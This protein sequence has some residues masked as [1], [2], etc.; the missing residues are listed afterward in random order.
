M[1]YDAEHKE[2]TRR[3]VLNEAA[4][5]IR[6]NGPDRIGIAAIM[7]KA[8]LTHGGFYAHFKSKDDLVAQAVTQMFDDSWER[9]M[10]R[11]EGLEPAAALSKL[12]DR[13]LDA[14]HRDAPDKGCPMPSLSGEL[15]RMPVEA[16]QRFADGAAR[17]TQAIASRLRALGRAHPEATATSVVSE[18]V[19][20]LSLARAIADPEHSARVLKDSRAAIRTRLELESPR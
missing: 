13:Y 1:R 5:A 8:G 16:R 11:V 9:I 18:M 14:R 10:A 3:R 2:Q 19:G 15:A 6:E 17:M 20:A 4:A 7:A 12:V